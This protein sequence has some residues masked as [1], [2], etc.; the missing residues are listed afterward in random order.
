MSTRILVHHL[1]GSK[2]NQI[3]QFPADTAAEL[4]IG[5]DPGAAAI[6]FD[7]PSEDVVSRRHAAIRRRA[8]EAIAYEIVDLGSSNGTFVNGLR[9][10]GATELQPGD[11][12]EL[13]KG[14]PKFSFDLDPRPTPGRTRVVQTIAPPQTRVI[15][16]A[17][18][19]QA[20]PA[21]VPAA[22]AS[23][24]PAVGR[25]TVLRMLGEQQRS[26]NRVWIYS[27]AA[28]VAVLL[29]I[30][31]GTLYWNNRQN[32]AKV[33][34]EIASAQSQNSRNLQDTVARLG[35]SPSEI[36]AKYTPATVE[37]Q[38]QWRLYDAQTGKPVFQKTLPFDGKLLP[39]YV[40]T[41]ENALVRWLTLDD[42]DSTNL[43][44]GVTG[45][46]LSSGSGFIV[47][48]QGFILTNKHV[49]APWELPYDRD[50]VGVVYLPDQKT[51]QWQL[52]K[53]NPN[54]YLKTWIPANGGYLFEGRAPKP[55]S[56]GSFEG[57]AD[58]M[59]VR[60]PNKT[61]SLPA[62]LLR[63]AADAD[64]AL[65]KVDTVQ[66]LNAVELAGPDDMVKVGDRVI[67]LGYP[68]ND[69]RI[70][71]QTTSVENGMQSTTVNEIPSPTLT[72]GIVA[73]LPG[74]IERASDGSIRH[75]TMGDMIEM[76]IN[77][78]GHGN[79][80]GPVFDASGRVIGLFTYGL[81]VGDS[82]TA[83][84]S[85]AVPIKYARQLIELQ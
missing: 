8:G 37:V 22:A 24:K 44:I 68:A 50:P 26:T 51:N 6:V 33:A 21:Q 2:A 43:P 67:V 41:G 4:V 3:E 85:G 17:E 15:S 14:G 30:V 35:M 46:W 34:T 52:V 71:I 83:N 5:R 18:A 76:T 11:N 66:S 10:T 47:N 12:V 38:M 49:A 58:V 48:S 20:V 19:A 42:E 64:V 80:G 28:A 53:L 31:G 81:E 40:K 1:S 60:F 36:A 13:G 9:I 27:A 39:A 74:G 73:R 7:A 69:N 78:S 56:Q 16:A 84:E 45:K 59:T 55:I 61:T 77:A 23:A 25:E 54:Q 57:R 29:A 65:I 72:E 63:A 75:T 62:H 79:S 32:E 70:L 82:R